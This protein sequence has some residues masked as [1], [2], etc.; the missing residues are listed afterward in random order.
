MTDSHSILT[1][2]LSSRRSGASFPG[3]QRIGDLEDQSGLD[4][5]LKRSICHRKT[6]AL[7]SVTFYRRGLP[8]RIASLR[9]SL[10]WEA[11]RTPATIQPELVPLNKQDL[12]NN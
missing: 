6:T 10:S 3:A 9:D 7:S 8:I 2:L 1:V 5:F 4:P 12:I 11:P